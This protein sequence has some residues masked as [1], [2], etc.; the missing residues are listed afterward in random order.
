MQWLCEGVFAYS[1]LCSGHGNV[2]L[3]RVQDS[4]G[5]VNVYFC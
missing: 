1:V 2:C 4:C 3:C 5:H